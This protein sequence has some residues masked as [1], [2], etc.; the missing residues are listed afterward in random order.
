M[1]LGF[2]PLHETFCESILFHFC[3]NNKKLKMLMV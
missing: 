2:F 3:Y 1:I